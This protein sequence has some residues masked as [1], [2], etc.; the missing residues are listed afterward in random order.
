MRTNKRIER[1]NDL[2]G[3][4]LGRNPYGEPIF[5]WQYSEDLFW[6]T[7]KSTEYKKVGSL[8]VP[9]AVMVKTRMTKRLRQWVLTLWVPPEDLPQWE[10]LF[11]GAPYPARGFHITT[12]ADIPEGDEP[13]L[14]DTERLIGGLRYQASGRPP[15]Q[16][17]RDFIEAEIEDEVSREKVIRDAVRDSFTAF[18]NPKPGARGGDTSAQTGIG[19]SP[20]LKDKEIVNA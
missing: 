9:V 8:W 18:L 6:P 3:S 2:L 7:K 20:V 10:N 1:L 11:P 14:Q 5:R 13:N 16:V 4:E 12:N 15:G 19:E 17:Y